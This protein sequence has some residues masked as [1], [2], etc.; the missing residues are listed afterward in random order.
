M[1]CSK[2]TS[3]WSLGQAFFQHIKVLSAEFSI[4]LNIVAFSPLVPG[5][6]EKDAVLFLLILYTVYRLLQMIL[7]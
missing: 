6:Q 5:T 7:E 4:W 2:S 3:D 1:A